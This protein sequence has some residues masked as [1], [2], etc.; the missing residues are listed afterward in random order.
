MKKILSVCFLPLLLTA[1]A[2]GDYNHS[3]EPRSMVY[4]GQP[5]ADLYE[6]F[7]TPTKAKHISENERVLI[8][9]Q[10][11]V[12][13]EWAY[14]YVR[15]CVM[16][17]HLVNERVVS[18][19]ADGQSCVIQ[20]GDGFGTP[21]NSGLFDSGISPINSSGYAT[22]GYQLPADAFDGAAPTSYSSSPLTSTYGNTFSGKAS[23]SFGKT[24]LLPADAFDGKASATYNTIPT[25]HNVIRSGGNNGFNS[26]A[27]YLPADAFDGKAPTGY[28]TSVAPTNS[29]VVHTNTTAH[30]PMVHSDDEEWGLFDN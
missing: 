9:I 5:V 12:E 3:K 17:F 29:R 14:R 18:W 1:C 24:G 30:Q 22:G 21:A 19:S 10:Q 26:G 15:G 27:G 4:Y 2:S 7:G 25:E 11:E 20:T 28:Q 16:K 8:Y 6:N 23:D 13:K